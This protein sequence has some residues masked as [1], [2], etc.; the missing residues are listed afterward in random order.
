MRH[1]VIDI[2][3]IMCAALTDND[4]LDLCATDGTGFSFTII[5]P[6]MILI[7]TA[8]IDPI[9]G[10]AVS[11]DAFL[12]NFADRFMQRSGLFHRDGIG[13]GQRM[14]FRDV[15]C[16]IGIDVAQPGKKCLVEQ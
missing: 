2:R 15:Q 14:Q 12:Q 3:A 5:H 7:F 11:A 8:A 16:F 1:S 9:Y 4:T 10:C 13:G 6:K